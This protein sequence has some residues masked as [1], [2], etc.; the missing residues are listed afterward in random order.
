MDEIVLSADKWATII[1]AILGALGL[2]IVNIYQAFKTRAETKE[3]SRKQRDV[4][5]QFKN[6]G[7]ASLKDATDRIEAQLKTIRGELSFQRREILRLAEVDDQDRE[8]AGEVH[9]DLKKGLESIQK[10]LADHI[11][12]T[13]KVISKAQ[14][15][16]LKMFE[17][18][19]KNATE[20]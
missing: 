10:S 6:D 8:F 15:E 4:L 9:K 5:D 19:K 16:V 20:Q 14:D 11:A 7:G 17:K 2:F 3:I 18:R 13:P 12:D 1:V